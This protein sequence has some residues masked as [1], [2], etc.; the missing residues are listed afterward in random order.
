MRTGSPYSRP[1]SS[2]Q[3][4]S[5]CVL[6]VAVLHTT[7]DISVLLG[8]L[9]IAVLATM[10]MRASRAATLVT[11][12]AAYVLAATLA[13]LFADPSVVSPLTHRIEM[14]LVVGI[15]VA[16]AAALRFAENTRLSLNSMDLLVLFMAIIVPNLPGAAWGDTN[17]PALAARVAVL[18]YALLVLLRDDG[19]QRT[20]KPVVTLIALGSLA[21]KGLV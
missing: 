7:W 6:A 20:L 8:I 17:L 18:F 12:G 13:M 10:T 19:A 1:A 2:T 3:R 14:L 16:T 11:Q 21:V 9:V 5:Y 15:A 4:W